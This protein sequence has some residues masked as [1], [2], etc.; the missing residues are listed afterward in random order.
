MEL[1]RRKFFTV[2]ATAGLGLMLTGWHA[3]VR[4]APVRFVAALPTRVFP[5]KIQ[6]LDGD[7]IKEPAEWSG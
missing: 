3:L 7:K 2:A 6:R 5:G 1:T 4:S